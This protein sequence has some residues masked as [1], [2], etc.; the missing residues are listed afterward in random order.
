[1]GKERSQEGMSAIANDLQWGGGGPGSGELRN[2][3]SCQGQPH[4]CDCKLA[5]KDLQFAIV[6]RNLNPCAHWALS[7]LVKK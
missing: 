5:I 6:I 2:A 3:T 4:P 1:M 7:G